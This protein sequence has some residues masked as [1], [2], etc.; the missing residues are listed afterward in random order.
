MSASS[1]AAKWPGRSDCFREG[2]SGRDSTLE[3]KLFAAGS[4]ASENACRHMLPGIH[5]CMPTAMHVRDTH[6]RHCSVFRQGQVCIL[7]LENMLSIPETRTCTTNTARSS[8]SC[9]PLPSSRPPLPISTATEP[10][11][12]KTSKGLEGTLAANMTRGFIFQ[13]EPTNHPL[14]SKWPLR[15]ISSILWKDPAGR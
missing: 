9:G 10:R 3:A 6:M 7:R 1:S 15:S 11:Q 13:V 14:P 8:F 5:L 4:A 12:N 2:G